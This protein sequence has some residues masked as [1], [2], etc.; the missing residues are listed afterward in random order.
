MDIENELQQ[1]RELNAEL[2]RLLR[3]A[4][5]D[6]ETCCLGNGAFVKVSYPYRET[7][8]IETDVSATLTEKELELLRKFGLR[9]TTKFKLAD[10]G[11]WRWRYADEAEEILKMEI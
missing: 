5:E 9:P 1:L 6:I 2:R 10:K 8:T 3:L 11:G 7:T 4:L